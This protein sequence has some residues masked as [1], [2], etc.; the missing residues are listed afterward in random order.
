MISDNV[1]DCDMITVTMNMNDYDY[2][3]DDDDYCI[4]QWLIIRIGDEFILFTPRP[5]DGEFF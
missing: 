3:D 1:T 2:D 4:S 5:E